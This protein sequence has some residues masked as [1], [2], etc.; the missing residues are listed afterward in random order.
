MHLFVAG[1]VCVE[2]DEARQKRGLAEIDHAGAWPNAHARSPTATMRSPSMRIIAGR[3][4]AAPVP[5]MS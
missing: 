2:V 5:S 1:Q 4:G 3:M